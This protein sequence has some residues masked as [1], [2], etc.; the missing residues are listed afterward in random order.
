MR[1]N[2]LSP[3]PNLFGGE[4]VIAIYTRELV[5]LGH[6]VEIVCC[7][8]EQRSLRGKVSSL[9]RTGHWPKPKSIG[10]SHYENYGVPYHVI[11]HDGPIVDQDL[12]D[13]DAVV[14]TFWKTAEWAA[15][16]SPSKGQKYYCVQHDEGTI[17]GPQADQT[18]DLALQHIY[19]SQWIANRVRQ[20]HP[21]A[22]G[23]V[24]PNA[25]DVDDFDPG[26]RSR[27]PKPRV[28]VMYSA[29][30]EK[31]GTDV[32]LAAV[33]EARKR[34]P[35][36][37][38]VAYGTQPP[39]SDDQPIIDQ[40]LIRPDAEQLAQMYASCSAWL[41]PSRFEG[42]GLPILEAMASRTPV[43]G[44]PTGA[45]PELIAGGGGIL[46]PMKNVGAMSDA[47]C[48]VHAFEGAQWRQMSEAAFETARSH[49]WSDAAQRFEDFLQTH[50]PASTTSL[51]A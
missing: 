33:G 25:I 51:T 16:L 45:A 12:S 47:I 8:P 30:F 24:I 9:V 17:H 36:L 31:K 1:V 44:T 39:S 4:R 11:D 43:I 41:F 38:L 49:R 13:A 23:I 42:F 32:A 14:A 27:P 28:G 21:G 40:Y 10:P 19:V 15:K 5:R 18:Y 48:R 26:P 29:D 7:R 50:H 37:E 3:P 22:N 46:V 2:F 20:R 6:Q 34:L 35:D